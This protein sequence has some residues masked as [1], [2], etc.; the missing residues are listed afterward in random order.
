MQAIQFVEAIA[1]DTSPDQVRRAVKHASLNAGF[2]TAEYERLADRIAGGFPADV[3]F[4]PDRVVANGLTVV[5]ALAASRVYENQFAT[6]VSN[7]AL[8]AH[9]GGR[10]RLWESR[11]FGAAY[12]GHPEADR[13]KY[14]ALNLFDTQD[15]A[16]PR[17]GS[18][19]LR[20]RPET[21]RTRERLQNRAGM[22]SRTGSVSRSDINL[23]SREST[24]LLR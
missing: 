7:G 2:D 4:H 16:C 3:H 10:R 9:L 15:G 12:D 14:G 8:S 11:M 5:E 6:G 19:Y 1:G 23:V 17:F 22:A 24:D 18:C 20:L 13:P 21:D